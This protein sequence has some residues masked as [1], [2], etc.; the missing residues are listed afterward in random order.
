[1]NRLLIVC[2]VALSLVACSKPG[3]SAQDKA[4]NAAAAQAFLE[5]N[6]KAPGVTVT[7]SG[8]QYKVIKSGPEG[9]PHPK[10]SDEVKVMYEGTLPNGEKFDSSYDSGA[11]ISFVL[12]QVV[13]GWTE[14]LQLMKPGD[15]WELYIPPELGYGENGKGPIPPNSALIFKIELLDVFPHPGP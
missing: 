4:A 9:G 5:K 8:L 1:M 15:V 10:R 13:P 12:S 6:A 7:K 2:F 3:F 11:P 14:G